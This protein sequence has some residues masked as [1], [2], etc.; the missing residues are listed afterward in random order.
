MNA[1]G[2]VFGTGANFNDDGASNAG[3]TRIFDSSTLSG[4]CFPGN[5]MIETDQE[6]IQIKDIDKAMISDSVSTVA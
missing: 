2:D 1:L 4:T 6:D 5:T 3:Q